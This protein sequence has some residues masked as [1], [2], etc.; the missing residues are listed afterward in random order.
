MDF[1]LEPGPEGSAVLVVEDARLTLDQ[2]GL[3]DLRDGID[4]AVARGAAGGQGAVHQFA[5]GDAT[6][7]VSAVP[8]GSVRLHIDR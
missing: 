7:T 8:G 4:L 2:E 3:R 6:V 1:T 5:A